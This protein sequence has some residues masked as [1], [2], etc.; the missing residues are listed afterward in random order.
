MPSKLPGLKIGNLEI[1][2]PIVQGGMGVKVSMASLAAAVAECGGAGTIASVGLGQYEAHS[3]DFVKNCNDGL[4]HEIRRAKE[5]TKGVVGVN[6]MVALSNYADLVKTAA[7]EKA[8]F[9]VS[10]AGLP[11]KLPELVDGYDIKL[12]PIV[13]S[14]RAA[15]L[16]IKTWV[17]R[18]NRV[19]DAVVVEGPMAGGHLGFSREELDSRKYTL[20]EIVTDVIAAV[21]PYE[22]Q[23]GREIPVIAGGGVFD[24]KDIARFLKLGAKGVQ[25]ATRF[26]V[27]NECSVAE[28][29][30]QAYIAA[31]EK[32]VVLIK[33]PVGLPGRAIRTKFIDRIEAG[34]TIPYKCAFRCLRTCD[35][36]QVPYCI[37]KAMLNAADGKLDEAV[38]F[39]GSNVSRVKKIVPVRELMDELVSEASASL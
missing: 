35:P 31:E 16:I 7:E 32:D 11:L 33:S 38:V 8:D 37:A 6:I 27:T 10:G 25:M 4:R 15:E 36:T 23:S 2:V 21:K 1:P 20:E 39:A 13:S 22:A 26:V 3:P 34:E 28:E 29:F 18:Y 12:I 17:K 19:Q 14:G 5:L 24:G 30:K 9:I